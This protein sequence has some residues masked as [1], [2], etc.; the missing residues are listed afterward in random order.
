[1]NVGLLVF[2]GTTEGDPCLITKG[3]GGASAGQLREHGPWLVSLDPRFR[4]EAIQFRPR[5]V[6][7]LNRRPSHAAWNERCSLADAE[8][9]AVD[10][11]DLTAF[12]FKALPTQEFLVHRP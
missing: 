12:R 8:G 4:I 2:L 10:G 9:E 7:I 5:E 11:G 6:R 1:M 3:G